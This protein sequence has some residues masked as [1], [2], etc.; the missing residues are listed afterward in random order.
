M[1]DYKKLNIHELIALDSIQENIDHIFKMYES[2]ELKDIL[3]KECLKYY[4]IG[5]KNGLVNHDK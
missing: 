4:T 2:H 5:Y 1:I 3:I